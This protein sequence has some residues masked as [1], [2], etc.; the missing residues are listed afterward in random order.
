MKNLKLKQDKNLVFVQSNNYTLEYNIA[1]PMYLNLMF[2]NE[3]GADLFI[4]SGCDC[5]ERIDEII[6]LDFPEIKEFS[7]SVKLVF[8][9]T[10]SLWE[11]VEYIFECF[12]INVLYSYRVM[13]KGK[14]DNARFFEG[15]I[16]NDPRL[17]KKF[18]PAFIG[19]SRKNSWHRPV[20]DFMSSSVPAF[21]VVFSS[22]LNAADKKFFMY[23][24][25]ITTRLHGSL[26]DW[27]GRLLC[28]S[29]TFCLH[30]RS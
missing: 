25:D 26:L 29:S 13:G 6:T 20:K 17:D 19:S 4:P 2:D 15:F 23:Y 5:D 14:L 18:R 16:A 10:T 8:S 30:G 12:E 1:N 11:K 28:Y 27:G 21:K 9:G 7:N 3:V 24:E 22:Q